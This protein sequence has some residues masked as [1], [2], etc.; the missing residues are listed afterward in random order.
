MLN[1]IAHVLFFIC[2]LGQITIGNSPAMAVLLAAIGIALMLM[3]PGI[4]AS[5]KR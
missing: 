5:R 1:R 2:V 4:R 3:Q